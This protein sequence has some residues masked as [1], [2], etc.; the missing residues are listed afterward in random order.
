M[1]LSSLC[2]K[3]LIDDIFSPNPN[4][5]VTIKTSKNPLDFG[6]P[7]AIVNCGKCGKTSKE[8][9]FYLHVHYFVIDSLLKCPTPGCTEQ[10]SISYRKN[11]CC[12][13]YFN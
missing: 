11:D 6:S 1:E 3:I 10:V 4:T 7:V 13:N 5:S 12:G 8:K 2:D 9:L